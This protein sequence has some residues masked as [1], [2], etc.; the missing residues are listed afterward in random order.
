MLFNSNKDPKGSKPSNYLDQPAP[1][2]ADAVT[3]GSTDSERKTNKSPARLEES[4]PGGTGETTTDMNNN[5]AAR[6]KG[7]TTQK[8]SQQVE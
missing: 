1:S 5:D 6:K 7:A 4:G 3:Q 2:Q 8:T